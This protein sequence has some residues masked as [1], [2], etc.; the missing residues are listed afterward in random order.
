MGDPRESIIRQMLKTLGNKSNRQ[1]NADRGPTLLANN[2]CLVKGAEVPFASV[3]RLTKMAFEAH[4]LDELFD[5]GG[6][7]VD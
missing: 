4:I 5:A 2:F 3:V 1:T 6:G 7:V